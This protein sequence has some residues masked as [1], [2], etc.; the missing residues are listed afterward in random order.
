MVALAIQTI[1]GIGMACCKLC[2]PCLRRIGIR[3]AYPLQTLLASIPF[4]TTVA[5]VGAIIVSV[6][7]AIIV[8]ES[9]ISTTAFDSCS[10]VISTTAVDFCIAVIA[11]TGFRSCIA[12]INTAGTTADAPWLHDMPL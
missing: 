12:V 8:S 9:V 11:T 4:A 7:L 10:A 6:W 3:L 5:T 2:I 1:G